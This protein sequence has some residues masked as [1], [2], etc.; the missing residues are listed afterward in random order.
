MSSVA[1]CEWHTLGSVM[2]VVH[3]AMVARYGKRTA[4][5][6]VAVVVA[7]CMLPTDEQ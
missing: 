7:L 4:P 6:A 1:A 5:S 3:R 2:R